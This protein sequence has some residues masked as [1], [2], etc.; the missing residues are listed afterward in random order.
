MMHPEI[1]NYLD[2]VRLHLHLD[3]ATERQVIGELD[4]YFQEKVAELRQKDV[5]EKEAVKKAIESFGRARVVA[6]LM[7]EAYSRGSWS[8]AVIASLPHLLLASLFASH[9]WRNPIV[10]SVAFISIVCVT[11]FGWWHG[12]PN[13]LYSWIGYSLT[14]LLIAGYASISTIRQAISFSIN[15]GPFPSVWAV[16]AVCALFAFSL[17]III[18]TTNRVVKRDWILASIMLVPLP[19]LG[20]WLFNIEGAGGL[21]QGTASALHQWDMPM[22][23]AFAMLGVT[24]AVFIRLRRRVLKVGAVTIVGSIALAMVGHNLWG[25]LGFFGLLGLFL[26][27]LVFL[28]TP[29]LIESKVR[30]DERGTEAWWSAYLSEHSSATE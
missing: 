4:T 6:R 12:K 9:L 2:K 27:M 3:P 10:A 14:P 19:I 7:Y 13:W 17:F 16:L 30:H 29:A 28:F 1:K 11:L 24:S 21:F 18:K 26:L 22:A 20:S 5:S 23:S 15:G 8:D 25:G